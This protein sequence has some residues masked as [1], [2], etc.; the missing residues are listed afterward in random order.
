MKLYKTG[1]GAV[2]DLAKKIFPVFID[3]IPSIPSQAF[4]DL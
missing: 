2:P 3:L 1:F 4:L